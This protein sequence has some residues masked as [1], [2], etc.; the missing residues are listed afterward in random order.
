MKTIK[1]TAYIE[2][3]ME[4]DLAPDGFDITRP[5]EARLEDETFYFQRGKPD[6]GTMTITSVV[7]EIDEDQ[8]D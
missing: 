2:V 1:L 4:D 7:C 6:K 8:R 3:E 5:I